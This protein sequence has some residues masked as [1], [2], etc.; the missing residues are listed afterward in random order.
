[1]HKT[2]VIVPMKQLSD[3]KSRLKELMSNEA[4]IEFAKKLLE[5][6]LIRLKTATREYKKTHQIAVLTECKEVRSF[7]EKRETCVI[8]SSIIN[9]LS[10][11]LSFG[12][13]WAR[14]RGFSAVCII[15]ADLGDPSL[16]DLK[17]FIFFPIEH[18]A[19]LIC[20][21]KDF[22]T[23]ALLISPPDAITFNYGRKSF[24]KHLEIANKRRIKTSILEL[25]SLT[26]DIDTIKDFKE[27]LQR[28]P[29][30]LPM[31]ELY[32]E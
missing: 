14:S 30:F 18:Y 5:Q 11:S 31:G 3:A 7:V 26:F 15:P 22:G 28:S 21:S 10:E 16:A 2:L 29:G 6:T 8:Q 17:K 20:P 1:M 9:K 13:Q 32:H 25:K 12:V 24:G 19:M 4:R 27:L 23:N